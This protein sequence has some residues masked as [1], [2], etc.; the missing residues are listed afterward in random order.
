[1]SS[2]QNSETASEASTDPEWTCLWTGVTLIDCRLT[3]VTVETPVDIKTAAPVTIYGR[4]ID[5]A[6]PYQYLVVHIDNLS[7][8]K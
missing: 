6:N 4:N 1:M 2:C 8:H 7:W 5:Q 3:Q